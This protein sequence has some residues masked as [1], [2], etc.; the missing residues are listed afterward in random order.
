M[1]RSERMDMKSFDEKKEMQDYSEIRLEFL[2]KQKC[3]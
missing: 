1:F 3:L 2:H